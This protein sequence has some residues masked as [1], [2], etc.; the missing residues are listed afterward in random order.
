MDGVLGAINGDFAE[1]FADILFARFAVPVIHDVVFRFGVLGP[2][3]HADVPV[4]CLP[5]LGVLVV[6]RKV[7]CLVV[8]SVSIVL[9]AHTGQVVVRAAPVG[10][11]RTVAVVGHGCVATLVPL[12]VTPRCSANGTDL[13]AAHVGTVSGMPHILVASIHGKCAVHSQSECE[14]RTEFYRS[15]DRLF[16]FASSYGN[17][18]M[19]Y[20]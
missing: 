16:H 18:Y 12:L 10:L 5:G 3:V 7:F 8:Y 13:V 15:R 9:V 14:N 17:S 4:R 1:L 6:D 11:E 2:S 19:S 20:M